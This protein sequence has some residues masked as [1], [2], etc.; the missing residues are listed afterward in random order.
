MVPQRQVSNV[1]MGGG[2]ALPG[3]G[4]DSSAS[5]GAAPLAILRTMRRADG[6]R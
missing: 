2:G 5:I 6:G 1:A 3:G 4:R